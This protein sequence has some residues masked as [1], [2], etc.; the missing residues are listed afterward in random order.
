MK[1]TS[2]AYKSSMERPFRS[3]STVRVTISGYQGAHVFE[4]DRIVGLRTIS[5][6]D[7]ISRSLPT[8]TMTFSILDPGGEY[9]LDSDSA[10]IDDGLLGADVSVSFGYFV[11]GKWEWLEPEVYTLN[12]KPIY[13]SGETTFHATK[14][15]STLTKKYR[16]GVFS[17]SQFTYWALAYRVLIDAGLGPDEFVLDDFLKSHSTSAP[18]PL[19]SH[20]NCL[21]MIA[22]ALGCA[23]FSDRKNRVCIKKVS[24]ISP[25][26]NDFSIRRMD[27]V[28]GSEVMTKSDPLYRCSAYCYS[29]QISEKTSRLHAEKLTGNTN[30]EYH[31]EYAAATNISVYLNGEAVQAESYARAASFPVPNGDLDVEIAGNLLDVSSSVYTRNI[32]SETSAKSETIDN[33]LVTDYS[34]AAVLA[35]NT[36]NV[37][38]RR[39][40]SAMSYRGNPEIETLDVIKYTAP[41]DMRQKNAVIVR[42]EISFDGAL[43][44]SLRLWLI[45][46]LSVGAL[47]DVSGNKVLDKNG[48]EIVT[49]ETRDV[50]SGYTADEI[51]EFIKGVLANGTS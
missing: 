49:S 11:G 3:Y 43:S 19:D 18:M 37:C 2:L 23:I 31:A 20:K 17:Y 28:N 9:N 5:E 25:S 36:A 22:H 50:R 39:S 40:Y 15:L 29:Y 16:K 26:V 7:P 10:K 42:N 41:T 48:D 27:V 13:K 46:D 4:G 35:E 38:R 14:R 51:N 33:K 47:L 30:D 8:E 45:D 1:A 34:V 44:G 6:V 32:T 24:L 21:Q 12:Q